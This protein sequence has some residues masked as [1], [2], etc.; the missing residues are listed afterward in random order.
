MSIFLVRTSQSHLIFWPHDLR[1]QVENQFFKVHRYFLVQES[2]VFKWMFA[3]PAG[4][5]DPDGFSDA[6]AIPLPG[7]TCAEMEA[8]QDF[9]LHECVFAFLLAWR[10][11]VNI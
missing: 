3:C 6:R 1:I 9:F 4:S 10:Y 5:S 2:D 8:L 7:V 11:V